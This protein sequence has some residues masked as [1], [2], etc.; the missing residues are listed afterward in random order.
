MLV[1]FSEMER[2]GN[3]GCYYGKLWGDVSSFMI[4]LTLWFQSCDQGEMSSRPLDL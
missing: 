4:M 1:L 2:T 3:G